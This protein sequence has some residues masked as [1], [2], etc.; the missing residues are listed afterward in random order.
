[1]AI[2]VLLFW[3]D[4]MANLPNGYIEL[5]YIESTGT[6]YI[7]TGFIPKY[8]TRIV[9][10]V[11]PISVSGWSGLFGNRN[12]NSPTASQAFLAACS[13]ATQFRSDYYG[14]AKT[15]N[16]PTVLTRF[17]ADKNKNVFSVLGKTVTNTASTA[18]SKIKAYIFCI[19]NSGTAKYFIKARGYSCQIYDNNNL[20]RDYIPC[21]NPEGIVGLYDLVYATFYPNS[22]TGDFIGGPA[23]NQ[24]LPDG[25]TE[26]EYIE[27]TGTQYIDMGFKSNQNTRVVVKL[28]TTQTGSHTVFGAD[29]GWV[30][31]GF[32]LGVGFAHYG[33]GTGTISGLNDGSPHE[34]DFNKN[35]IFMDGASVLTLGASTFSIPYNSALFANIRS[36]S[37]QEITTMLL[38]YCKVYDGSTMIRDYIPCKNSSG[39]IG[40][41]DLVYGT[42]YSN[43][44]TGDF[45]AGPE[46]KKNTI[47]INDNNS[48]K[49]ID[50]KYVKINGVWTEIQNFLF[51][52]NGVWKG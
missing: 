43:A 6:Q 33:K 7:D 21:K 32:A 8:N 13:S 17:T 36:G 9:F 37:V 44:G 31:N 3:G 4:F 39:E 51:K 47:L 18:Q 42:F 23:V 34:I 5:E 1:M 22:G 11:Q 10:D 16:V 12:A 24:V 20:I 49:E 15:L 38:Y 2:Y 50:G 29:I 52:E 40:L 35:T 48:L 41:Y 28:S 27:S 25:Y 45:I 26:L 46:V 14:Q 30:D 19:N